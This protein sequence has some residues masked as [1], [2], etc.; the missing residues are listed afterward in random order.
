M[1][2]TILKQKYHI[3]L[4]TL[5]FLLVVSSLF[6][7]KDI[8][9]F[10]ISRSPTPIYI[11]FMLGVLLI[12]ASV[13][14]F[15]FTEDAIGWSWL[16]PAKVKSTDNGYSVTLGQAVLNVIYGRIE[17]FSTDKESSVIILPANEYFDDECINDK[18][19][20]L[21]AYIQSKFPNQIQAIQQEVHAEIQSMPSKEVEKKSG[22]FQHSYGVGK[23][24]FLDSPLS[25]THKIIL[26]A[27]T[28]QRAGQ[29]LRAE[30][31]FIFE[32]VN[33]AYR[34]MCDKRLWKVYCP[35]LGAGHGCLKTEVALFTLVLAWSEIL[36]K[37]LGPHIEINIIVF[38]S[39]EKAKPKPN[40]KVIKRILRLAT[41]MFRS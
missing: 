1:F 10:N 8:S 14:S 39:D 5:G 26:A 3:I 6:E 18:H 36:C 15:L 22:I 32:S 24:I 11:L 23:C 30:I 16:H 40:P 37:P 12:L 25:S 4:L 38:K 17:D 31:S 35:L 20:S 33:E 2:G 41:G 9:K 19:S 34:I 28:S 7:I 29:G 21:G 13:V 27:V